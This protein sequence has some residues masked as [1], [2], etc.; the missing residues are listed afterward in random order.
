MERLTEH[1]SYPWHKEERDGYHAIGYGAIEQ[2][3]FFQIIKRLCEY[4][5]T[6][7]TPEEVAELA[8]AKADGRCVVL[9]N[10]EC[11]AQ[12]GNTLYLVDDGDIIEVMHCGAQIDADGRIHA[13]VAANDKIFPY[14]QPDPEHD[15][16][17]TEW[18]AETKEITPDD[19]GKTVF[20]THEEAEAALRKEQSDER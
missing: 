14:R 19:F 7:L 12:A 13:V 10:K 11:Y 18:C 1:Y 2:R 6:G 9:P 4:E 5:D 20:L 8:K 15:T 17:P 3:P 16:D